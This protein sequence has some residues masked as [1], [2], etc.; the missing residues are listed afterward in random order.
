MIFLNDITCMKLFE[1]KQEILM[2]SSGR[3]MAI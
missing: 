1:K 2:L 3:N